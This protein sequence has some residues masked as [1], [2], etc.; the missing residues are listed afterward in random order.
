MPRPRS[1]SAVW[2]TAKP[3]AAAAAQVPDHTSKLTIIHG[4]AATRTYSFTAM[5]KVARLE[6][7]AAKESLENKTV[8]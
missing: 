5:L 1:T 7:L 2:C 6:R 3:I 8:K 4:P